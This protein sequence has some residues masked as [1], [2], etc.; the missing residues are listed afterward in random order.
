M[1]RRSMKNL[2]SSKS[3]RS[4]SSLGLSPRKVASYSW[5]IEGSD[6]VRKI[7]FKALKQDEKI[8]FGLGGKGQRTEVV[9]VR[10]G[11]QS[12][13]KG[14]QKGYKVVSVNGNEVNDITVKSS[15]F[16]AMSSGKDFT[17]SFLVPD[18]P[19]WADKEKD[20]VSALADDT[21]LPA[22]DQPKEKKED[23]PIEEES[24]ATTDDKPII[25]KGKDEDTKEGKADDGVFG[26]ADDTDEEYKKI[27]KLGEELKKSTPEELLDETL[28]KASKE[29]LEEMKR[30]KEE[31][32]EKL[33]DHEKRLK[34]LIK[35][36]EKEFKEAVTRKNLEDLKN[37]RRSRKEVADRVK[38]V[39]DDLERIRRMLEL[40]LS[41][42]AAGIKDLS[43]ISAARDKRLREME[44]AIKLMEEKML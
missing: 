12:Y 41:Q 31:E 19:D 17:I 9:L 34:E 18:K 29:E 7:T 37:L 42:L 22:D 32:Y 36:K 14:L 28:E 40:R 3:L 33:K 39:L 23:I 43:E 44:A 30:R 21:G 16:D 1:S 20:G 8:G 26:A 4:S 10:E 2:Q 13:W 27:M 24:K 6:Y 15:I 35:K 25:D 11:T 5:E 38:R